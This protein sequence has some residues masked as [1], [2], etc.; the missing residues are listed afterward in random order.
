MKQL[1]SSTAEVR[2]LVGE[3]PGDRRGLDL[4][5]KMAKLVKSMSLYLGLAHMAKYLI[6]IIFFITVDIDNYHKI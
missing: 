1:N 2:R 3:G 4:N 6:A 5:I